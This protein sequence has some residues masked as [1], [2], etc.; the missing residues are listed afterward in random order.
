MTLRVAVVTGS[1]RGIGA[2]TARELLKEG[3]H[4]VG[5]DV[6]AAPDERIAAT[7]EV[8]RYEH[9]QCDVADEAA[10]LRLFGDVRDRLGRIDVLANIAGVVVVKPVLETTWEDYRHVA[11]V[12]IGGTI[13]CCKHAVP[14]MPPGSAIVNVASISGHIGQTEHAVYA[15]T[16]GA[17]IAFG[18]ALAWEL[19]PRRIRVNSVSPGSVDTVMLRSDIAS[20][21]ARTGLS[22]EHLRA[23]REAE[24]A[25]GRWA[26]PEEI[27][28]A[29]V[30]L[31]GERASFIT[32][33][34][35]LVDSGWVAR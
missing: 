9:H 32:G 28:H 7:G 2:A 27:A 35:L 19:A 33:T 5:A 31:A 4:V 34:D 21:S 13:F 16:K 30:F 25:L 14:L 11:D 17:V 29:V 26:Q 15:S 20:E 10:V 1:A 3:Y 18:R 22:Y 23:Q 12:N 6:L 8:R 24:Q